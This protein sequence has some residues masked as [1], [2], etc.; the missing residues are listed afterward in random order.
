MLVHRAPQVTDLAGNF[1]ENFIEVPLIAGL[2]VP[3]SQL[4]GI[5]LPELA[6]PLADG[7]VC[8]V[9]AAGGKALFDIAIRERKAEIE[10]DDVRDNLA[11]TVE[12]FI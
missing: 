11:G 12:A 1:E 4:L 7:F 8:H 9:Y 2:R 10:P 3:G 5:D 6:A